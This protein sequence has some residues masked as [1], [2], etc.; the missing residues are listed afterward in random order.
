MKKL[1]FGIHVKTSFFPLQHVMGYKWAVANC[2]NVQYVLKTDDDVFV[3]SY[4]LK[5]FLPKVVLVMSG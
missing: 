2:P 3:D 5:E 4:H 1:A